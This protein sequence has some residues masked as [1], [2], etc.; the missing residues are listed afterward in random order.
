MLWKEAA[1]AKFKY[2]PGICLKTPQSGQPI[3]RFWF[4]PGPFW[5]QRRSVK[6]GT[7]WHICIKFMVPM[8]KTVLNTMCIVKVSPNCGCCYFLTEKQDKVYKSS[9][10]LQGS[11]K[12]WD[13]HSSPDYNIIC[14]PQ[15]VSW[16]FCAIFCTKMLQHNFLQLFLTHERNSVCTW[17][18]QGTCSWANTL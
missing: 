3:S 9:W 7:V 11:T 5:I 13:G 17:W 4:Q 16:K 8:R 6:H 1:M 2:Y 18:Q 10:N 12:A 14:L 15:H